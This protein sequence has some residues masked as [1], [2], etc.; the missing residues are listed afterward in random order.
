MSSA[1]VMICALRVKNGSMDATSMSCG[2]DQI[3][4]LVFHCKHFSACREEQ[5]FMRTS[6]RAQLFKALLA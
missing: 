3:E 1:A 5:N 6:T 4:A 2:S